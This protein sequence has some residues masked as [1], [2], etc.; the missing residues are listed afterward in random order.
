MKR[1]AT[2]T[3]ELLWAT[4]LVYIYGIIAISAMAAPTI[5]WTDQSDYRLDALF[6]R[7]KATPDPLEA[8][9]IVV[10]I[11]EIWTD[12]GQDDMNALMD[13]G[14]RSMNRG[15]MEEAIAIFNRIVTALPN[16]AEGWNK[17]ATAHYLNSDYTASIIDI[18]RTLAL[19]PRH[20]GAISGMGLIFLARGDEADA[21]RAFEEV[22]KI[23]PHARGA[24]ARVKELRQKLRAQGA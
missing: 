8:E 14:I 23:N 7:L 9:K 15:R 10:D 3:R 20:F 17:R 19:E 24:R 1:I 21:L 12:S 4:R 11:W 2:I 22:L 16:Y 13:R 6:N 18:E 5:G